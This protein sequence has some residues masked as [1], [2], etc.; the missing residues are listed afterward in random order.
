ML[1]SAHFTFQSSTAQ[2]DVERAV[3]EL[4]FGRPVILKD[5]RQQLAV[6]ALDCATPQTFKLFAQAVDDQHRLFLS[7]PRAAR[8]GIASGA[9][10]AIPLSGM[11]FEGTSRLSYGLDADAPQE[12]EQ[13]K[14][15]MATAAELARNA[16][17]LP[18]VVCAEIEA[19]DTRFGAC[20]QLNVEALN[21]AGDVRQSFEIIART[22]VPLKDIGEAEFIV[23]RGG[24]AQR[25][26]IAIVV[27]KPDTTKPVPVRIHSS[28]IT[29]DLC[30]SLKCDCGDQL[31][32][33]LGHL[34]DAG[35]GVLLYLDQEG[36]GTGIGAKMRAYGYQHLGIDTIDAD[37]ELGFEADH[38]RYEA[39]VSM[40]ELLSI[41][42]V[43]LFT[44][45]PTKIEALRTGGIRVEERK[46]VLGEVT[47]E[48][49][50]YLRTKILRADHMLDIDKL[51]K[52]G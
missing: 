4:R 7:P 2:M 26:Q 52:L 18:A 3:A 1:N 36:R 32:N 5:N 34:K 42:R 37:A 21:Q 41:S 35:G 23:F 17:L 11:S 39:A 20:L 38:R 9:G 43:V 19:E 10:I 48:N 16:L 14:Q 6:L 50:N 12:W 28:C 46:P 29:G 27:G 47:A 13:P 49:M 15:I 24:L 22:L 31:C 44:N 51:A 33:G 8:L 45:N 30:G 25:D 40:L